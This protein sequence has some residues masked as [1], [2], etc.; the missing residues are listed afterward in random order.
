[1]H[2]DPKQPVHW[3]H[4]PKAAD[5]PARWDVLTVP[6]KGVG[7]LIILSHDVCGAYVHYERGR[8]RPCPRESCAACDAGAVPRW[9]GYLAVGNSRLDRLVIVRLTPAAMPPLDK[10]FRDHR[11]LR[12]AKLDLQRIGEK[13]NGKLRAYITRGSAASETLPKGPKMQQFLERMWG[14]KKS[15]TTSNGKHQVPR[16]LERTQTDFGETNG[17]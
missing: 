3:S 10:Y 7:G 17:R 12:G 9:E 1:M 14:I 16:P 6:A 13:T 4:R 2:D 8:T 15:P 5:M 11:T